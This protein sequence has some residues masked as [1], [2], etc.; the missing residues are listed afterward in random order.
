MATNRHAQIR[1][2]ILDRCFSN[3]NRLFD[4]DDLL[5]KVNNVLF[6]L[7]TEGIKL[8]QLQYDIEHMKSDAGWAIEIDESL[9]KGRKK[10][11]RY[12][13]KSFS[14]ANHPLNVNDV[15]QLETT[16]AILSRYKHRA[17]FSWLEELIPRMEQAFQLVESGDNG[18]ISYQE[19][20]DLKGREHIGTLFNMILKRKQV[21]IAYEPYGKPQFNVTVHPY[22]I[23]Q[24]NNRWFLFCFNGAYQSISNYPLDRINSIEELETSFKPSDINWLDYFDDIIGVTKPENTAIEKI[25]L[26][27]SDKRINYVLT[28][29]LHGSQKLDKTDNEGR[30]IS[31]EVIPNNELY[32]LL[33]SFGDDVI[34]K[35][36]QFVKDEMCRRINNMYNNYSK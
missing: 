14:I 32:Q 15:E 35:K 5:N 18:I 23:K 6:E 1:Y 7:G 16:I 31:I 22:H 13:D 30:T 2:T 25:Y 4:Y 8:R 21:K 24:Y 29:P 11:F 10:A 28:K 17:E 36:P 12:L 34:V 3:H 26:K 19:N 33:L 27:F 20:L 9:K